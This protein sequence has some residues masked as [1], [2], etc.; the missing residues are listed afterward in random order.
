MS[1]R[2]ETVESG[3]RD[4]RTSSVYH[5]PALSSGRS[6]NTEYYHA[7][8]AE[9]NPEP[10]KAED[11][12]QAEIDERLRLKR[13]TRGQKACYPC[14][15]RKVGCNYEKPCQKCTDR[16]HPELC[17]YEPVWKKTKTEPSTE[18][19]IQSAPVEAQH[20]PISEVDEIKHRLQTIEQ[21]IQD[22]RED[23]RFFASGQS[24]VPATQEAFA[25]DIAPRNS[26]VDPGI[27]GMHTSNAITGETV[28][29]GGNSVPA[30]VLALTNSDHED[31]I[32]SLSGK[33]LLP[34]FGLDN[35][36][37]TYPFVDLWGMP[38]ESAARID[39]L[40]K[41]LPNDADCLH[42]FRQYRDTAHVLFPGVV[43]IAQF[44]SD[45]T[46]FLI[47]RAAAGNRPP[48]ET[49]TEQDLYGKTLHWVGLLFATLA[50]GCQ[51]S[52][53]PRKERQLT[54]QVY[55]E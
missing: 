46:H 45:L 21:S 35:E 26:M 41:L 44:E 12:T 6:V 24:R 32:R 30:M 17:L 29:L 37:A 3:D 55:G 42:Y 39:G 43:D 18:K 40:C 5:S 8:P 10:I 2:R 22:L 1:T 9:H 52:L 47:T 23:L 4:G 25:S 13:K 49:A 33:S 28:H 20:V 15:Q 11:L 38:H 51:C 54:C 16:N 48:H 7:N 36:S 27:L 53:L 50:S 14:R 34:I 19:S 31:T